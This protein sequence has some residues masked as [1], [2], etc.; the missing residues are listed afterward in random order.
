MNKT[1]TYT[2]SDARKNFYEIVRD[3]ARGAY[4]PTINLRD[5]QPVIMMSLEEYESWQETLE[6]MS[7]PE[8]VADL[9]EAAQESIKDAITHEELLKELGL[10]DDPDLQLK[11]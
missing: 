10:E 7:D 2:A 9:K 1:I 5:S 3:T 11:S 4:T 6:V 8:L